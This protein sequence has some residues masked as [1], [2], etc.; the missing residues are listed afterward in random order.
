MKVFVF[1]PLNVDALAELLG[2]RSGDQVVSE[3][4]AAIANGWRLVFGGQSTKWG[5]SVASLIQAPGES[6]Q[7]ARPRTAIMTRHQL[8][9]VLGED[10]AA[11][12]FVLRLELP[13]LAAYEKARHSRRYYDRIS[14][15]VLARQRERRV[16]QHHP[17]EHVQTVEDWQHS[18]R[19]RAANVVSEVAILLRRL[20]NQMRGAVSD[21]DET[22]HPAMLDHHQMTRPCLRHP[23]KAELDGALGCDVNDLSVHRLPHA[24]GS[25]ITLLEDDLPSTVPLREDPDDAP[26]FLDHER[27][28]AGHQH[29]RDRAVDGG[30]RC[31]GR[32][33]APL[34]VE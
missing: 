16:R 5:C 19:V 4:R 1:D 13:E 6:V 2:R 31:D 27:T 17:S 11:Y 26:L 29:P 15:R 32:D 20:S 8:P 34:V 22:D 18:G 12:G 23:R 21:R 24:R 14:L 7:A 3:G 28:D 10:E 25:G 33:V 9:V 30:F